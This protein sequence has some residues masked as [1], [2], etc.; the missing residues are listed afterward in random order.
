MVQRFGID[1]L[2]TVEF[3]SGGI[4]V[5]TVRLVN[6]LRDEVELV[7]HNTPRP[8]YGNTLV[9]SVVIGKLD[10]LGLDGNYL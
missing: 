7:G 8:S 4:D 9:L 6:H 3:L 10:T 5:N 1:D 2:D